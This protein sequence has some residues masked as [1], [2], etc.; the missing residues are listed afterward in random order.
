MA[1]SDFSSPLTEFIRAFPWVMRWRRF[2]LAASAFPVSL[3]SIPADGYGTVERREMTVWSLL[4]DAAHL[5]RVPTF[6]DHGVQHPE[7]KD[8][9]FRA[10]PRIVQIRYALEAEW[11]VYKGRSTKDGGHGQFCGLCRKLVRRPEFMGE[12]F[13]R[14]DKY[15]MEC[16][17]EKDGPGNPEKWRWAAVNHH[18]TK[19]ARDLGVV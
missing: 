14:G 11:L 18:I 4:R 1:S 2:S 12:A 9:D 5:P 13:S 8:L 7:I 19:T 15:I 3:S 16:A 10:I 6:G 17:E